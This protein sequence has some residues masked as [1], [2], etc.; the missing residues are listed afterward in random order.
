[1]SCSCTKEYLKPK[2]HYLIIYE[3]NGADAVAVANSRLNEL[4]MFAHHPKYYLAIETET[5]IFLK[6]F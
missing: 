3:H 2:I 5:S 6:G 4:F 1:V